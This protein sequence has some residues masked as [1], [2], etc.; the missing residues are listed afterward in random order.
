MNE[1]QPDT[2]VNSTA[3]PPLSILCVDDEENVLRA[4]ER[5]FR[6]KAFTVLTAASGKEGLAILA[7][8]ESIGL[9]LSDQRMQEM[10]GTVFLQGAMALRPDIPR[11]ILTGYADVSAATAAANRA[12][13]EVLVARG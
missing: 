13:Q 7:R 9:I 5:L 3:A 2:L 10:T 12:V 4:L 11:M 6:Q 1:L 8:D